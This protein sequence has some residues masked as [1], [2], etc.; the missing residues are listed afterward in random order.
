MEKGVDS[1]LNAK[2]YEN[3]HIFKAIFKS[4]PKNFLIEIVM[5]LKLKG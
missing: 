3:R 1:A 5:S 2:Y 4:F